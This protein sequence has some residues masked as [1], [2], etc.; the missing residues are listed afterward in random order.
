MSPSIPSTFAVLR[1]VPHLR[2]LLA[3]WTKGRAYENEKAK[4]KINHNSRLQSKRKF[5]SHNRNLIENFNLH[6]IV[7]VVGL[8][9]H[10]K[11][12]HMQVHSLPVPGAFGF[13][14]LDFFFVL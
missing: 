2:T 13:F 7:G 12:Y 5:Q 3:T 10:Q 4:E 6:F 9:V 11:A 1:R 8:T 14:F